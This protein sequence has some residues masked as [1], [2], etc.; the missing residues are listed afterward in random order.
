MS[1]HLLQPLRLDVGQAA[2]KQACGFHELCRHQPAPRFFGQ[3]R[4][5][6]SKEFD[7]AGAQVLALCALSFGFEADV[8]QQAG[9]HGQVQLLVAG[10]AGVELPL[11]LCHHGVQLAV[12]VAPLAHPAHADKVLSQQ[13][14]VLAVAELVLVCRGAGVLATAAVVQPLPQLE[15]AAE[16]TLLIVELG[17]RL[18]GLGLQLHGPVAHILHTEGR[19][20]HQ[21]LVERLARTCLQNHAA[22]ARVQRQPG[23]LLPSGGEFIG[24]VHRTQLGEQLIAV[25]NGAARGALQKRKVLHH[26]QAQRLHAQNHAG[27]RA[28]QNLRVGKA[29]PA[30][31]VFLVV[32]PNAD[33][34]GHPA[35]APGALVGRRLA[36]GLHQQLLDLASKTVAL[37]ARGA[38]VDHVADARHSKRGLC[39]IGGQHNASPAMTVKNTVL[40]GLA[41]ARKQRQH[42]GVAQQRLVAQVPAQVVG[43]LADFAL[44]RQKHQDIALVVGIAPEFVHAIGDGVVQVVITRLF[45]RP[46][47]LLHREHAARHHDDGRRAGPGFEVVGK[48]LCVNG[49]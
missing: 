34:V 5:G 24:I 38:G 2:P 39:H 44:T 47:A 12:D 42:L 11:V 1:A 26:A 6:V 29:R 14:L 37:H 3:M 25:G 33:A 22:H 41:Q 32:Q 15:V 10:R 13:L 46:I 17:V 45:K 7:A 19:G 4:A 9:Q 48:A 40:L 20:D 16:F 31:K 18:I 36:D 23:Q 27:E 30:V 8:A 35:A 43:G 28:A 21:H 49:G